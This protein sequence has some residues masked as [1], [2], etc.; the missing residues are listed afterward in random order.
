MEE[1]VYYQDSNVT[2]TNAR[3]VTGATVYAMRNISSVQMGKIPPKNTWAVI[4]IAVGFI[5]LIVCGTD[6]KVWAGVILAICIYAAVKSKPIYT[7]RINSNSG[8]VDGMSSKDERYI[9]TVLKAINEAI[10][11]H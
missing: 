8:A 5:M 7:V 11:N 9:L 2:V 1:K 10:I 3:F 6:G 4:G